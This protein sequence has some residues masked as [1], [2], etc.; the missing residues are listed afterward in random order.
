MQKLSQK[1]KRREVVNVEAE[2][3]EDEETESDSDID[4]PKKRYKR[5]VSSD[6]D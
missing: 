4:I 2:Q 5:F 6:T 3:S 1:T